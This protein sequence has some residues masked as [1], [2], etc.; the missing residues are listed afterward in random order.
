MPLSQHG[1]LAKLWFVGGC[2]ALPGAS[3]TR[4]APARPSVR[5]RSLAL[6]VV[7]LNQLLIEGNKESGGWSQGVS[8]FVVQGCRVFLVFKQL[9]T[10]IIQSDSGVNK[11]VAGK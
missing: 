9:P 6:P 5:A 11:H 1:A 8:C 3:G 2:V 4:C 10:G 7:P